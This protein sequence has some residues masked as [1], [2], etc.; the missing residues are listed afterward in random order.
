M[1]DD[2][3]RAGLRSLA[4]PADR[5]QVPEVGVIQ[6]RARRLAR[7]SAAVSAAVV[8]VLAIIAA[9]AVPRVLRSAGPATPV[10]GG[11]RT[12]WIAPES[13]PA[14]D[15]GPARAPF[16]VGLSGQYQVGYSRS[17]LVIERVS[18]AKGPEF[19]AVA[20]IYP[21]GRSMTFSAVAAAGDG[22][23]FVVVGTP[24]TPGH[25]GT[26]YFELRLRRNGKP[27]PLIR[28][29]IK[30]PLPPIGAIGDI[31]LSPNGSKLAI[32]ARPGTVEVVNLATGSVRLWSAPGRA[33]SVSWVDGR[34][35]AVL[36]QA[37]GS[38]GPSIRVLDTTRSGSD[39]IGS[40]GQLAPS[41]ARVG[42]FRGIIAGQILASGS[43][44]YALTS[45]P[46]RAWT[47][48][49]VAVVAFPVR[50]GRPRILSRSAQTGMGSYCGALWVDRSGRQV[51]T[52]CGAHAGLTVGSKFISIGDSPG[53]S[54]WSGYKG[55]W[56]AW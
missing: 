56:F 50:G 54:P 51:I 34:N 47:T 48:I 15:A 49:E 43:A 30:P 42:Q 2:E 3:L 22:R 46:L 17:E 14:P 38:S 23:T 9:V 40:S 19:P 27:A 16:L 24:S 5:S 44:V 11:S 53:T 45:R 35:L 33:G 55:V 18:M 25:S 52:S 41:S 6:R 21:P 29:A 36:W 4:E 20:A 7:R 13:A 26:S 8:A 1:N 28:L 32:A 37:P 39:L 12:G 31:S 10:A